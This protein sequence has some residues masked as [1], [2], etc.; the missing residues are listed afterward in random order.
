M[1][2]APCY[3]LIEELYPHKVVNFNEEVKRFT[4]VLFCISVETNFV[5]SKVGC[6]YN[7][8]TYCDLYVGGVDRGL[9]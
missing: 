3:Y 2:G 6:H 5:M 8:Y 7:N 4:D 9:G 1:Q